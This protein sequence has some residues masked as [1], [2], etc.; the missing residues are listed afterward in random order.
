MSLEFLPHE[1][2]WTREK[3]IRFW[4]F[5]STT[6]GHKNLYFSWQVGHSLLRFVNRHGVKM[7]GRV[8][9]FGCGPGYLLER[10]MQRGIS[11]EGVDFSA[12]SVKEATERLGVEP[13]FRRALLA[14]SLP[15][16]LEPESYDVVFLVETAEHLLH[17]E[18]DATL[19]EIHRIA[20]VD[21]TLVLTTPNRENLETSGVI[22]PDC[23]CVFHKM[24]HVRSWTAQSLSE[25]LEGH[26]FRRS[27]CRAVYLS[28]DSML[29]R[30]YGLMS[31]L[32]GWKMPHLV[33]IGRKSVL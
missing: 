11:C 23:G 1:V 15:V 22:C 9:D 20:R 27:V 12:R 18:L 32:L 13:L 19:A 10:M 29:D 5:V 6:P 25:C 24:Q 17:D 31:R 33:Y 2:Q 21:G 7:E 28:R 8:L 14:D 26:G 16:G 4:D 3:A 30:L